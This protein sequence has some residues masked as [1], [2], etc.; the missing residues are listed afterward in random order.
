MGAQGAA[1]VVFRCRIAEAEDPEAM[2]ARMAKEHK[3]AF[4]HPYHAAER[5]LADVVVDPAETRGVLV[6]CLA[7]L[8]TKPA[9]LP[10]RG[11]GNSPQ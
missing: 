6:R 7:M 1:D 10:S 9:D 3:S 8:R 4:M 2:R 11:H 5:G